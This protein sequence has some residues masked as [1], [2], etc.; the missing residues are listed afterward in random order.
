MKI[1]EAMDRDRMRRTRRGSLNRF[2]VGEKSKGDKFWT[3]RS[4][5]RR[6]ALAVWPRSFPVNAPWAAELCDGCVVGCRL[7]EAGAFWSVTSC[8]LFLFIW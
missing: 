3:G 1:E 7:Q 4:Q 8:L 6:V 2:E 5:G